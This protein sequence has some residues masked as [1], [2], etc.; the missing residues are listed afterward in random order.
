MRIE[1]GGYFPSEESLNANM[2][3]LLEN[4][5]A[6]WDK[7]PVPMVRAR[8]YELRQVYAMKFELDTDDVLHNI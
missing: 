7:K 8:L 6:N 1:L 3:I 2:F 4:M 5:G